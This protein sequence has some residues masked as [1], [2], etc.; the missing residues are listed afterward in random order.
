MGKGVKRLS[1]LAL[2]ALWSPFTAC[3][4]RLLVEVRLVLPAERVRCG[5]RN[6]AETESPC[7]PGH[8]VSADPW[9]QLTLGLAVLRFVD[10]IVF[11]LVQ[12]RPRSGRMNVDGDLEMVL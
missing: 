10:R 2:S 11:A 3:P 9:T 5:A 6:I 12:S 7:S 1:K 8:C 4:D